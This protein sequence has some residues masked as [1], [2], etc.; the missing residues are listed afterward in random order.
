VALKNRLYCGT[1]DFYYLGIEWL[2][3]NKLVG[4]MAFSRNLD[5][6]ISGGVIPV[7]IVKMDI[8]C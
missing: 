8:I 4:K 1:I 7:K 3:G 6:W 2:K 5:R